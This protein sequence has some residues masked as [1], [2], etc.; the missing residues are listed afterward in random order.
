MWFQIG[1][2]RTLPC[3]ISSIQVLNADHTRRGFLERIFN[4]LLS[5]NRDRPY[6]LAGLLREVTAEVDK[7][8]SFGM[9]WIDFIMGQD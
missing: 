9:L 2:N 1:I 5:A 3:S 8:R 4:P 6:S 7:L